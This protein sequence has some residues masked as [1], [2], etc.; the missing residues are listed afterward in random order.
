MKGEYLIN[1]KHVLE[2]ID[3]IPPIPSPGN[4]KVLVML[5]EVRNLQTKN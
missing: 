3:S 2:K 1:F 5:G 4:S